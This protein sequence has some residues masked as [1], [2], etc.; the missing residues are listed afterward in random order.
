VPVLSRLAHSIDWLNERIGRAVSWLLLVM[1]IVQFAIVIMRY[2]YGVSSIFVQESIV[3][4][5]ATVFM[6][7]SAYT[8]MHDGHVRVDVF[9]REAS[10][11]TK[12]MVDLFGSLFLLLPVC[13]VFWWRAWPFVAQS[14]AVHEGSR[15]TSGIQAIY[16][17]KSELLVFT[18][19]MGLQGIAKAIHAFHALK[20]GVKD[21]SPETREEPSTI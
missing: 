11:R 12:A 21:V 9:Y 1:V 5:H 19:L 14:W 15:E 13:V 10:P 17:L 2:V 6:I 4:M 7:A 3:Y 16:L 20:T 18:V 8:L